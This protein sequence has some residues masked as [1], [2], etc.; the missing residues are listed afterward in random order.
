MAVGAQLIARA[1]CAKFDQRRRRFLAPG[2]R[3]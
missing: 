2:A 1:G 3:V